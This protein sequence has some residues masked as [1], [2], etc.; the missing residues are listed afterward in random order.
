MPDQSHS[1]AVDLRCSIRGGTGPARALAVSFPAGV[2]PDRSGAGLSCAGNDP[3]GF[4][5]AG[6]STIANKHAARPSGP[7]SDCCRTVP[8]HPQ[9]AVPGA[10]PGLC[11]SIYR[12]EPG[13]VI[14]ATAAGHRG[15]LLRGDPARGTAP[16]AAV[17]GRVSP[18]QDNR[19]SM[20]VNISA[21]PLKAQQG[22]KAA[23]PCFAG[24]SHARSVR[25]CTPQ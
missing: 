14:G 19:S 16:G 5:H 1:A 18:L 3:V 23:V 22:P 2:A 15:D 25:F 8:L 7:S 13:L 17:R 12:P 6:L 4:R 10:N 24:R 9:S 20:V 21:H 11:R